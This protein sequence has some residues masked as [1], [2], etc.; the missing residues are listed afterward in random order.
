MEFQRAIIWIVF[1]MSLILLWDRW[2]VYQGHPA[3]FF[4][5]A[6]QAPAA[7]SGANGPGAAPASASAAGGASVPGASAPAPAG[8][9]P[10]AEA[11]PAASPPGGSM[12]AEA[13]PLNAA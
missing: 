8:T 11:G 5:S 13:G 6:T 3:V 1:G 10:G 4:P 9:V 12:Q 2:Q 7:P